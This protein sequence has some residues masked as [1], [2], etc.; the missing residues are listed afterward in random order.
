MSRDRI[1]FCRVTIQDS[2]YGRD[3]F[4]VIE[5]HINGRPLTDLWLAASG[6]GGRWLRAAEAVW[7]GH[8]LWTNDP[9][10]HEE[11]GED[12]RRV[13]LVCVDGLTGCG[14]AT[15]TVRLNEQVV[16]WRD[17][18]T[19]PDG[20]AVALGPFAFNRKDY[21]GALAGVEQGTR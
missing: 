1:K 2:A 19:V 8:R 18:R 3:P 16:E 14:G 17:F 10:P 20:A 9:P 5:I 11:L 12:E 7:P 6:E 15:A 4:D 21:D 13:V